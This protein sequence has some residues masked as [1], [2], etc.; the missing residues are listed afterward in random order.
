MDNGDKIE[1][2]YEVSKLYVKR[3]D[4][5]NIVLLVAKVTEEFLISA[6]TEDMHNFA[7]MLDYEHERRKNIIDYPVIYNLCQIRQEKDAAITLS[8]EDHLSGIS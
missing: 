7:T 1:L 6:S 5:E 4:D 3:D 2:V 8:M